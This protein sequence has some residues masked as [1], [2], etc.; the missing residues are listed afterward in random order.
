MLHEL[1][2]GMDPITYA[3][4]KL[5]RNESSRFGLIQAKT[6]R[7]AFLGKEAKLCVV[8]IRCDHGVEV[9]GVWYN[10]VEDEFF[11]LTG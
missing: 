1:C 8:L 6:P 2:D 3:F 7:Q 11:M 9:D 10:L 4:L 5:G